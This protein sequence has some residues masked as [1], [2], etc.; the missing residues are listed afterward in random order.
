MSSTGTEVNEVIDAEVFIF[1]KDACPDCSRLKSQLDR[2][3]I[4]YTFLNVTKEGNEAYLD[5]IKEEGVQ[6][7]PYTKT[8][9]VGN[10]TGVRPDKVLELNSAIKAEQQELAAA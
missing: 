7:M 4:P 1:T 2:K 10:W 8:K 6:Q 3:G 5:Q 9:K